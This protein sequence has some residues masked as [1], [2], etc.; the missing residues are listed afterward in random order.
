MTETG[1][2]SGEASFVKREANFSVR[3]GLTIAVRLAGSFI[4]ASRACR[5]D[6]AWL[7]HDL[8][9]TSDAR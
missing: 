8:L 3:A 9:R 6:L 5:T 7:A 1:P 4:C 2:V